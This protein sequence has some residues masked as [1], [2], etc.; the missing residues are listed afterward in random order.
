MSMSTHTHTHTHT[1]TYIIQLQ[2]LLLN[3]S[4]MYFQCYRKHG[5]KISTYVI[6]NHWITTINV[7][8][9]MCVCVWLF[10]PIRLLC[11]WDFSG[12]NIGVGCH[13]LLQEI[14]IPDLGIEPGSSALQED[15][16]PSEPSGTVRG[17]GY[18]IENMINY[19]LS[20]FLCSDFMN[21][22]P[23]NINI[24]SLC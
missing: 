16:L 18:M 23:V 3:F 24:R 9:C 19:I 5:R 2:A 11:P 6:N 17:I 7:C 22:P 15:S 20:L 8:V 13:F 21:L 12:K 10:E 14:D 1:H 4:P